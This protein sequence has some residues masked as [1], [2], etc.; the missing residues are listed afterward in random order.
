MSCQENVCTYRYLSSSSLP[1]FWLPS[2]AKW[3]QQI[4]T[5]GGSRTWQWCPTPRRFHH[6]HPT[7]MAP[8]PSLS[9]ADRWASLPPPQQIPIPLGQGAIS[10]LPPGTRCLPLTLSALSSQVSAGKP[11]PQIFHRWN[12]NRLVANDSGLDP[13]PCSTLFGQL[14]ENK[15]RAV[16]GFAWGSLPHLARAGSPA[17]LQPS[18]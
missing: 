11:R 8:N 7:S 3:N 14:V 4:P 15:P 17:A 2:S 13:S 16:W 12:K 6:P 10:L 18:V 9:T 1:N 5:L